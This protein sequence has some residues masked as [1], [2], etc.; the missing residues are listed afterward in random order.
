MVESTPTLYIYAI[1]IITFSGSWDM[2]IYAVKSMKYRVKIRAGKNG[3]SNAG[4]RRESLFMMTGV[5][6]CLCK[7]PSNQAYLPHSL[8]LHDLTFG[9]LDV[10]CFVRYLNNESPYRKPSYRHMTGNNRSWMEASFAWMA[11]CNLSRITKWPK[12]RKIHIS[13]K[14]KVRG[15]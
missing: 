7:K 10:W 15:D 8:L 9:K 13:K 5:W 3:K 12:H 14:S 4:K 2:R 11:K 6:V 1:I